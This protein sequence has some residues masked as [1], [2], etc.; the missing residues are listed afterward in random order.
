MAANPKPSP[1]QND[2]ENTPSA[3]ADSCNSPIDPNAPAGSKN[4]LGSKSDCNGRPSSD[5]SVVEA[6]D[7]AGPL[8]NSPNDVEGR[9]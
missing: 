2:A 8:K 1:I 4:S 7:E 9:G 5:G 6:M 3:G